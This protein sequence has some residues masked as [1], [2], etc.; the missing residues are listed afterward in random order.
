MFT[1]NSNVMSFILS[2]QTMAP[3]LNDVHV[4]LFFKDKNQTNGTFSYRKRSFTVI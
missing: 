2:Q 1:N 4:F 3:L